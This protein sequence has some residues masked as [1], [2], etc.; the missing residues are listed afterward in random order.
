[1]LPAIVHEDTTAPPRLRCDL[2]VITASALPAS[3]IGPRLSPLGTPRAA[4][5][6]LR[7]RGYEGLQSALGHPIT[8]RHAIAAGLAR[9]ASGMFSARAVA[10]AAQRFA[11]EGYQAATMLVGDGF[12]DEDAACH[13][14]EAVLEAQTK[15]GLPIFVET[16]RGTFTQDLALTLAVIARFPELRFNADFSHYATGHLLNAPCAAERIDAMTPIVSRVRFIHAR[17]ANEHAAQIHAGPES[18][19][20]SLFRELWT[21]AATHFLEEAG[22]GDVLVFAPELLPFW[23]GYAHVEKDAQGVWSRWETAWRSPTRSPKRCADAS[24][25]RDQV[26]K[27]AHRAA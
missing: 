7:A 8:R 21:R 18:A 9:C 26:S 4:C 12:E 5:E 10:A 11:R 25:R 2:N 19:S 27:A 24:R 13:A 6:A 1:M 14:A 17:L 23:T 16:H 15:S 22:P 3:S 20:W